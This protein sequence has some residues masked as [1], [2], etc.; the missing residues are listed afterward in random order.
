MEDEAADT[1]GADGGP[2]RGGEQTPGR[3]IYFAEVKRPDSGRATTRDLEKG[4]STV[5]AAPPLDDHPNHWSHVLSRGSRSEA[6]TAGYSTEDDTASVVSSDDSSSLS[7]STSDGRHHFH[8]GALDRFRRWRRKAIARDQ[9]RVVAHD[10]LQVAQSHG[11]QEGDEVRLYR[12]API[13]SGVMAPFAVML[14]VPGIVGKWYVTSPSPGV[15]VSYQPNPVIL[16]VGLAVSLTLGVVANIFIILRFIERMRPQAST[17]CAVILLIIHDIINLVAISIFGVIHSVNDGYTFAEPFYL[18]IASTVASTAVTVSLVL[19]FITTRNFRNAGS[20]LTQKQKELVIICMIFLT[21]LSLGSLVFA[22]VMELNFEESIYFSL[23]TVATVGFGD[24]SPGDNNAA[25]IVLFFFAPA[26][27]ILVALVVASARS[28]ILESF[29][30]SYKQRRIRFRQHYEERRQ[31]K[32]ENRRNR[33]ALEAAAQDAQREGREVPHRIK[34]VRQASMRVWRTLHKTATLPQRALHAFKPPR[35]SFE[36]EPSGQNGDAGE[37][38]S[39]VGKDGSSS[40]ARSTEKPPQT[41]ERQLSPVPPE[42]PTEEEQIPRSASPEHMSPRTSAEDTGSQE[43]PS[44]RSETGVTRDAQS[45]PDNAEDAR[46]DSLDDAASEA[47]IEQIEE[48]LQRQREA[49]DA[50]WK[51][52]KKKVADSERNEFWVSGC[53]PNPSLTLC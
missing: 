51:A 19:D 41:G 29:E 42:D 16:D 30:K 38:G 3:S 14:E 39:S 18:T 50:D 17:V 34:P 12:K 33:Q 48:E 27:I 2:S 11:L 24:I 20:G 45:V 26:G 31:M 9:G 32:L 44:G 10:E 35:E 47:E 52:Y 15:E 7:E 1:D 23:V 25:R 36:E 6:S 53:S 13:F 21:Y 28:T 5:L 22:F 8:I 40:S 4:T 49:L 37:S 43:K 46:R